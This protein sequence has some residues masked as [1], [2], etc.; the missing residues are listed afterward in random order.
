MNELTRQA[1]L[2]AMGIQV[3]YPRI[4]LPGARQSPH[5][6]L[7][8]ASP[9]EVVRE[10]IRRPIEGVL[11]VASLPPPTVNATSTEDDQAA[12]DALPQSAAETSEV[13]ADTLKFSLRYYRINEQFAVID[14]LPHAQSGNGNEDKLSLLRNILLALNIDTDACNFAYESF[15]WPLIQGLPVETEPSLAARQALGGFIA[16]RKRLDGFD[17]LLVFA[18]QIDALLL[19]STKK[20][21]QRDYL[22][23]VEDYHLTITSSLQ[24]M[25][26]FPMLKKEVWQRLQPLRQ[27]LRIAAAEASPS[28]TS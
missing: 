22:V 10:A 27:R 23:K 18:G 20:A 6:E 5:Y 26:S 19:R 21:E 3:V 12:T 2:E 24:A 1:Y 28:D 15:D 16:M 7:S 14:E 11:S 4:A 25:L 9:V 8:A 17:N 13:A